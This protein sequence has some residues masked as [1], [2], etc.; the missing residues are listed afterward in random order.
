[1]SQSIF[2]KCRL[3]RGKVPSSWTSLAVPVLL[4]SSLV[5]T[6]AAARQRVLVTAQVTVDTGTAECTVQ[7]DA[8]PSAKSDAQG[9]ISFRE[10][11]PTDHYI[12]V[13]CP[14]QQETGYFIS[15]HADENLQL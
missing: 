14:G 8:D 15:P 12:H 10:V 4:L 6:P 9:K 1:M 11:D 5:T 3:S 13:R 2:Q 7:L